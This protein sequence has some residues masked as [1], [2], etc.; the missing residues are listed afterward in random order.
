MMPDP[1][2]VKSGLSFANTMSGWPGASLAIAAAGLLIGYM[3]FKEYQAQQTTE[4]LLASISEL[5]HIKDQ[6][7]KEF[8]QYAKEQGAQNSVALQLATK[9]IEVNTETL[10]EIK[11]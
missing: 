6:R 4:K 5:R 10:K 1:K 3:G 2:K 7:D 8:L 11:K 9:A